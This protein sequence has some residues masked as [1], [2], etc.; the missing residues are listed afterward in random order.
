MD[1]M[2]AIVNSNSFSQAVVIGEIDI[3]L[4]FDN[5]LESNMGNLR[6]SNDKSQFV[7]KTDSAVSAAYLRQ[8]AAELNIGYQEYS[9]EAI[10]AIMTTPEWLINIGFINNI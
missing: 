2:Y 7:I 6:Y 1:I 5:I 8:R 9:Y 10:R 4:L 3:N